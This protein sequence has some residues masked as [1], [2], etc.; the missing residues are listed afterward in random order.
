MLALALTSLLQVTAALEP[1]RAAY[2]SG[3]YEDCARLLRDAAARDEHLY[4][5]LCHF[6]LG[7]PGDAARHF[8]Q[9]LE[10][11]AGSQLPPFSSPKVVA[12]FTTLK[13]QRPR[14]D[15]ASA[16]RAFE[17]GQVDEAAR[18]LEVVQRTPLV[19]SQ[20]VQAHLLEGAIAAS[21]GAMTQA[22]GAFRAALALDARAEFSFRVSADVA[23]RFSSLRAG[24]V[25]SASRWPRVLVPGV[26]GIVLLI[27]G[28]VSYG[29]A[30]NGVAELRAGDASVKTPG[31]LVRKNE[32]IRVEQTLGFVLG[33]AG[34]AALGT[35]G[36]L[37]VTGREAP[38]ALVTDGA[39]WR[40][41]L[42][43]RW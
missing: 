14:V 13:D 39:Q 30:Q 34:L 23:A 33:G 35:A 25:A 5:G 3:Q 26:L 2:E 16:A 36:V 17:A 21:R 42:S 32:T 7:Q 24:P 31:D 6:A 18:Q 19:A 43:G 15:L 10:L 27:G 22:E 41:V 11:D 28:G 20:E 29:L 9:A 12:F 37:W 1:A 8:T 40:L 38:V 4:A